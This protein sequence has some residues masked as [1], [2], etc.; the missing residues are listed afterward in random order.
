MNPRV[1]RFGRVS[2]AVLVLLT[3]VFA[4]S[5]AFAQ[6]AAAAPPP[7]IDKLS[8][9]TVVPVVLSLVLGIVTQAINSSK[10][11]GQF[12][13]SAKWTALLTLIL[14]FLAGFTGVVLAQ[15]VTAVALFN[16]LIAGLYNLLV[17]AAPGL[18][19]HAHFVV[20]SKMAEM[21]SQNDAKPG[22]VKS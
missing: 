14:P 8:A 1:K 9:S 18:A 15:G 12:T 10:L 2:A 7:A 13:L 4:C 17:G 16:A 3:V 5:V 21:R 6:S 11:F 20:P 22:E 19:V